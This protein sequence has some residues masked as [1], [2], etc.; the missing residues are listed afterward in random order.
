MLHDTTNQPTKFRIKNTVEI[1][2]ESRETYDYNS[3]T[4]FKTSMIMSKLCNYN[5]TCIHVKAAI[6]V[7]NIAVQG[8]AVNDTNEKV[9][10]KNC[11]PF[12]NCVRKTNNTRVD[13]AQDIG[14]VL[15]MYDL[16]E[17]VGAYSKTSRSLWQYY[18]YEPVSSRQ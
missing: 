10:F 1:N 16:M 15:P 5:D 8:A 17:Y 3:D 9:I 7:P 13:D 18:K 2:D 12:T 14:I 11:A 6:T 4:K